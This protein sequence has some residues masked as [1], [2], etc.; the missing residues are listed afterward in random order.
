MRALRN[1][2]A[3]TEPGGQRACSALSDEA[4][5]AETAAAPKRAETSQRHPREGD[6]LPVG[7]HQYQQV[8]HAVGSTK[9][10]RVPRQGRH[11]DAA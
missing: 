9:M 6:V 11:R 8:L 1:A 3:R 5:L 10:R 7:L 2:G 4:H